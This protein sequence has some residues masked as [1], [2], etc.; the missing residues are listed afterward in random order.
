MHYVVLSAGALSK[1]TLDS[2]AA[3][4]DEFARAGTDDRND[5]YNFW[6][7]TGGRTTL[8]FGGLLE[9]MF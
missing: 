4:V 6:E 5:V 2:I 3:D 7:A 9:T 8:R 1:A